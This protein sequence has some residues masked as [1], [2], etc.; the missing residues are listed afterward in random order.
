MKKRELKDILGLPYGEDVLPAKLREELPI[1]FSKAKKE[2]F[3][4]TGLNSDF[5]N[6][7]EIIESITK[8][9]GQGVLFRIVIDKDGQEPPDWM[10]KNNRIQ[11]R[12][13][14]IKIRYVIVIDNKIAVT[15]G[16]IAFRFCYNV[17]RLAKV[18]K[19][20]LQ[21]IWDEYCQESLVKEERR[22]P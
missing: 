22:T 11:T 18:L 16:H 2:V 12:R 20:D 3:M 15:N 1:L 8:K 13:S 19:D 4:S 7:P 17:P 6:L 21:E 9:T 5:Y 10:T 14:T